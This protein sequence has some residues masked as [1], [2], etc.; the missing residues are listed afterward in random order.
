MAMNV[1]DRNILCS[2][3]FVDI[4]AYSTQSLDTQLGGKRYFN[5]LVG[6]ATRQ[7]PA[8]ERL[9]L[10]TG[11]GVVIGVTGDPEDALYAAMAIR[12]GMRAEP[13]TVAA[14]A[15]VRIGVNLGPVRLVKDVNAGANMIG[16]GINIAQRVMSFATPGQILVSR[17]FRDVITCLSLDYAKLF[18]FGCLH[19]D[20]HM[21]E[22][23]V[24]ALDETELAFKRAGDSLAL[25]A[26]SA[27]T[28]VVAC[29]PRAVVAEDEPVLREELCELLA[30]IWPELEIVATVGDGLAAMF[31]IDSF[32]P[33]IV[34]LDIEMPRMTGIEVARAVSD[35]T[36]VVVATAYDN[37]AIHAF[38]AGAIDYTLKPYNAARL[39][40][41]CQRIKQRLLLAAAMD[42]AENAKP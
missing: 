32:K 15:A 20:K 24:F 39:I 38:E 3:V 2:V 6:Q 35:R 16:D 42:D 40:V 12:R 1:T 9:V 31:A 11:D 28:A 33:D 8:A 29:R 30:E 34:F 41:T 10:D 37:H 14:P 22:H 4:V 17:S 25:R 27:H 23:E 18:S 5:E 36:H 26:A 7:I 13:D 19:E 21:R